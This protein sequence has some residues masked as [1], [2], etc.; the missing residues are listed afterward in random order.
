MSCSR[1][2]RLAGGSGCTESLRTPTLLKACRE[3]VSSLLLRTESFTHNMLVSAL[4]GQDVGCSS[5]EFTSVDPPS[6]QTCSQYF[7]EYISDHGGYV[8]NPTATSQC[9]F[10]QYR[11]ADEYLGNNFNVR[12]SHRWRNV[13]I[14]IVF[15]AFN[16]RSLTT[17]QSFTRTEPLPVRFSVSM[18]SHIC[19][20]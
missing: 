15:I 5:I 3:T 10:C 9:Q 4:G 1:S 12:Y 18:L 14:F 11:T 16:V 6:G 13:G 17:S 8:S 7:R 2:G 19:S 20:V